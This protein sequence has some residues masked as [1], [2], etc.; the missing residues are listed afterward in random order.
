MVTTITDEETGEEKKRLINRMRW[1]GFGPIAIDFSEKSVPDKPSEIIEEQR[2]EADKK[3]LKRLEEVRPE[4]S[5]MAHAGVVTNTSVAQLFQERPIWT[6][7]AIF[8]QFTAQE[9]REIFK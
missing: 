3:L 6:R 9:V 7:T 8:N 1:K 2:D 4:S 5:S